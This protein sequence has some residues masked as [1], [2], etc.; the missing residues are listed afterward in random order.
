MMLEK[1]AVFPGTIHIEDK[2]KYDSRFQDAMRLNST[3]VMRSRLK[4]GLV[5]IVRQQRCTRNQTGQI[6]NV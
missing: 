1:F 4:V 2:D 3:C 5:D 6:L